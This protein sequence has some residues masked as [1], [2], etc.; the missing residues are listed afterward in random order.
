MYH[1]YR[2]KR[3]FYAQ[4]AQYI[5]YI[6]YGKLPVNEQSY[7]IFELLV[8]PEENQR[9]VAVFTYVYIVI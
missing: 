9:G 5:L 1:P 3:H 6:L 4:I 8:S 2:L 7:K